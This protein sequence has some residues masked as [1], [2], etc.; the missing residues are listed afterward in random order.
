MELPSVLR[1][2]LGIKK[3]THTDKLYLPMEEWVRRFFEYSLDKKKDFY[4]AWKSFM[5]VV[6]KQKDNKKILVLEIPLKKAPFLL[7]KHID[8]TNI[9][10]AVLI[11]SLMFLYDHYESSPMSRRNREHSV[12][13]LS[14]ISFVQML[15]NHDIKK[16][17]P[18]TKNTPKIN[19]LLVAYIMK[20][21]DYRGVPIHTNQYDPSKQ[22]FYSVSQLERKA[23]LKP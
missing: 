7:Q 1:K 12:N 23:S 13:F 14:F 21:L 20:T 10:P 5:I 17:N 18:T 15:A 19:R 8:I 22:Q 16:L 3:K 4:W 6:R 2:N 11:D 9:P